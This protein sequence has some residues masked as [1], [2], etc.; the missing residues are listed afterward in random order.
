L[1]SYR[2]EVFGGPLRYSQ[3]CDGHSAMLTIHAGMGAE[4]RG[5]S[6]LR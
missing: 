6:S 1:A 3:T 4:A 5:G 2:A